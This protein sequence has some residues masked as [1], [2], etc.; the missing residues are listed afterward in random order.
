[1][2]LCIMEPPFSCQGK[3][4]ELSHPPFWIFSFPRDLAEKKRERSLAKSRNFFSTGLFLNRENLHFSRILLL[5]VFT[6]SCHGTFMKCI[7]LL[8]SKCHV[9]GKGGAPSLVIV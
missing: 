7:V 1:M 9:V 8:V 2:R 6:E 5:P 4:R 3:P